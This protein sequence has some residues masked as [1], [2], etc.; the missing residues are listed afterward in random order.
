MLQSSKKDL[1]KIFIA[2]RDQIPKNEKQAIDQRI[3]AYLLSIDEIANASE[4]L[5]YAPFR[6]EIDITYFIKEL[7]ARGIRTAFPKCGKDHTMTFHNSDY[8]E[9]SSQAY[10][11]KEPVGSEPIVPQTDSVC[12]L[13]CLAASKDGH[14]IG[15]GGGYYDRF[16]AKYKGLKVI[17]VYSSHLLESGAF[18][19]DEFDIPTDIIVTEEEIIR[20]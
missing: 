1:R 16:L 6:N 9:L 10:G 4:V 14:R 20:L 15:Y 13:P 5:V 3:C 2:S 12:I 7:K 18:E 8:D 19:T 11:I 17:A